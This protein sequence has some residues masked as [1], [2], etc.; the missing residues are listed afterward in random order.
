M[1]SLPH[2]TAG[3]LP[4]LAA[5]LGTA[6]ATGPARADDAPAPVPPPGLA[7]AAAPADSLPDLLPPGLSH[8]SWHSGATDGGFPCL[9]QLRSRAL[10]ANTIFIAPPSF[11]EMV[12]NTATWVRLT[13]R[14]APVLVVS[15][16]LLPRQNKG[17][18]AQCAA[19]AFDNYFRQ[20]GANL[21]AAGAGKIVVR[22]GWE[23]NIGSDSHPWGVDS[24]AQVSNYIAC[25]RHA[26]TALKAGGGSTIL[27]EWTNAKKTQNKA[28]HV[29][30]MYPGDDLVDIMG[31]HY[32]D[33]GPEKN[34]QA[35][36]DQYYNIT[37]NGQPWGIGTWLAAAQ[38]H[39]KRLGV[40]EWGV[41]AQGVSAKVADDP[42]YIANMYKFFKTN[43]AS[44]AYET[45]FNAMPDQHLLCPTTRFPRAAAM[46]KLLWNLGQ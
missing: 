35:T 1:S 26:A 39:G 29:M 30:Q 10:D 42:V 7:A 11:G 4:A 36:W 37:Y 5:I 31:V 27:T 16:A 33:S 9:A 20:T 8:L 3:A 17:Q 46:Y 19:G 15:L 43:A 45:Y 34:T 23:A 21:G 32:Y 13:A 18:F 41:W 25:W 12:H 14:K 22:L 2:A 24:P 44:I 28:L 6:L 38:A 40:A